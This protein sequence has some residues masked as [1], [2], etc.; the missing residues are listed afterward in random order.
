M[1]HPLRSARPALAAERRVRRR[2]IALNR[3]LKLHAMD[4]EAATSA[5]ATPYE[6]LADTLAAFIT[7]AAIQFTIRRLARM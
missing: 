2:R 1:E 5:A 6:N 3:N 7:L 4:T